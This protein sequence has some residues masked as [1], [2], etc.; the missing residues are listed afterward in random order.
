[1]T[2]SSRVRT[3]LFFLCCLNLTITGCARADAPDWHHKLSTIR[4]V[5]YSPST[6]NPNQGIEASVESIRDDLAVLRK[7]RFTG[8]VT[9]SSKGRLGN[10][11]LALAKDAGF[12][13]VVIGVWNPNDADE[14]AAAK[15][16]AASDIVIGIC[17]GNEGLMAH[18]YSLDSLTKAMKDIREATKKPVTTTEI[19]QQYEPTMLGL[20]DWAFPNAHPYFANAIEPHSAVS[21]TLEQFQRLSQHTSQLVLLK[22]VGLPTAGNEKQPL[23]EEA[24]CEY[25]DALAKTEVHFVYFEG[26]DLPWKSDQPVE[27]H[28][29][30]FH[31]DRTPKALARVLTDSTSCRVTAAAKK[32]N[33][34]STPPSPDVFYVYKDKDS[35][36][37]HF[38]PK[39]RMGDVEDIVLQDDWSDHPESGTTCI[40]VMYL[41]QG[42]KPTCDYAGPCGWS[43]VYWQEP[44]LNWG[45]KED[46]KNAGYNLTGYH[47]LKFWAR[48][49][50]PA[51]VE[52]KVGGII[53]L[54]GDSLRPAR[55][56]TAHLTQE[57][58]EY[59]IDLEDANLN[60]VIG[61]FAWTASKELNPK[62]VTFYLDEI[63]FV[64]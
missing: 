56:V 37:N 25:Y 24:Q 60:Y 58:A 10:E 50:H 5:D 49:D 64:H 21:W 1:M 45:K 9:Y 36:A 54:Y 23:S 26:F 8:L 7:A 62:G 3:K 39:G 59:S 48:A 13:G 42:R 38:D 6:G 11:L 35:R 40:K 55:V 27:P 16:A 57:W 43:G 63:R 53:G 20:V 52:F 4:W 61:G 41:A 33:G 30:I 29:G 44:A 17:V 47:S 15:R 12:A 2:T 18:R 22:E 31:S 19:I 51:V 28:W 14:L 34:S 32:A 46:W